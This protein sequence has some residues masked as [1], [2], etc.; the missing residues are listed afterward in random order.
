MSYLF[1]MREIIKTILIHSTLNM[2][3]LFN[4]ENTIVPVVVTSCHST[5]LTQKKIQL[6]RPDIS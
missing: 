1:L 3:Y 5:D 4:I 6:L 2:T